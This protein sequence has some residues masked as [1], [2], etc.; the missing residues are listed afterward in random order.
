MPWN[1]AAQM[2]IVFCRL[3]SCLK[4]EALGFCSPEFGWPALL[5]EERPFRLIRRFD[6]EQSSGK[7]RV[8]DDAASGPQSLAVVPTS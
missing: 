7:K 4:D 5:A 6:I 8:I 2:Q 3:C 1:R